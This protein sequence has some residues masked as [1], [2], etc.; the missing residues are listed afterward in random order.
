MLSGL[1]G[2]GKFSG[3]GS[4]SHA[5]MFMPLASLRQDFKLSQK[6]E[7]S[8]QAIL[9]LRD[10]RDSRRRWTAVAVRVAQEGGALEVGEG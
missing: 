6:A 7:E 1:F 10:V 5:P 3:K 4:H 9:K 2:P 8:K